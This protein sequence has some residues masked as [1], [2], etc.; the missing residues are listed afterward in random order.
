MM[1]NNEAN[2]HDDDGKQRKT[3]SVSLKPLYS[4]DLWQRRKDIKCTP[5]ESNF[6]EVADKAFKTVRINEQVELM[7]KGNT[8]PPLSPYIAS[9]KSPGLL[10]TSEEKFFE[11]PYQNKSIDNMKSI[12]PMGE[13]TC[14]RCKEGFQPHEEIVNSQGEVWHKECF[15]CC[16][17][18]RPFPDGLFFEFEQRK[19]CEYDFQV[20]YAPCCGRCKEFITGRVIKALK[21]NWHPHCFLCQLCWAQLAD[22][23]FFNNAGRALCF[24]CNAKEKGAAVGKNIC[25]KCHGIIDELPLR[26]SGETYHPYHFNCSKCSKELTSDAR[27]VNKELFCLRCH[28]NMGIPICGAC[29]RPIEERVVHALGKQWHTEHFVCAKC[30]KPFLGHRHYEKRGVAYCETHYHQLFGNLCSFCNSVIVGDSIK[31]F[32]KA[33][34]V[35]HF[36]CSGCDRK[37]PSK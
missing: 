37:F 16:Q 8:Y 26:I 30:E 13:M 18:F 12:M 19:Y 7:P 34:C 20:L 5:V 2:R 3:A 31:I 4:S 33:W 24:N 32:Q 15:V 29:H 1:A 22:K 21:N 9:Q 35:N 25:V 36:S 28:D 27:M 10:E 17:C 23:G 6:Q 14:T 11:V